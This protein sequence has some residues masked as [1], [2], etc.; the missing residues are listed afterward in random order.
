MYKNYI[1]I[2]F[3]VV[4]SYLYADTDVGCSILIDRDD[5]ECSNNQL[6]DKTFVL[7]SL[8]ENNSSFKKSVKRV[9]ISEE[10]DTLLINYHNKKVYIQRVDKLNRECPPYCIQPMNI[11]HIKTIGELEVL[12]FIS[13]LNNMDRI[14][15]DARTMDLYKSGTIP[16]AINIPYSM[17]NKNSKYRDEI[18]ELLGAKR[19][20]SRW[21]F[22]NVRKLL[23]FDNG[24]LDNQASKMIENLVDIGYPQNKIFYYRGGLNSWKSLGLTID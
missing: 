15:I 19:V 14:V 12:K 10:I 23:I 7:E 13:L 2:V 21:Y 17:L 24:I 1:L 20:K 16:S 22:K 11:A 4:I 6:E 8:E 3:F 9:R 18:L 5:K